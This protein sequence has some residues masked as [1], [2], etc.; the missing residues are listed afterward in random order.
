[1]KRVET[2]ELNKKTYEVYLGARELMFY[3]SESLNVTG[4][5]RSFLKDIEAINK[6]PNMT[7]VVLITA[8]TLHEKGKRQPIGVDY[9]DKHI[10]LFSDMN[11]I[12]E[13][14]G[15]C[16]VDINVKKDPSEKM[17]K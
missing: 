14:I 10:D 13:T 8:S 15:K 2:I 9:L 12:M 16:M 3:E 5:E 11:V 17:G 1:M 7:V 6:N 4:K